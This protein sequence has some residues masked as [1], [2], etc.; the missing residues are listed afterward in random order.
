MLLLVEASSWQLMMQ[1]AF[2]QAGDNAT[3]HNLAIGLLLAWLP[4]LILSSIVD[5]NPVASDSSRLK[6]NRLIDAVRRALLNPGLRETYIRETGRAPEEFAWT[7]QLSNED[8]FHEHFFEKFAGQGCIRW[9]YGVAHP[10]L[11]SIEDGYVTECG[12]GWLHNADEARTAFVKGPFSVSGLQW[13]DFREAWQILS[14]ILVVGGSVGGAFT[15]SYW[16]PT[17]GLGCR[18]GGY[19]I[20]VVI[21][22]GLFLVEM[23]CWILISRGSLSVGDHITRFGTSIQRRLS[24]SP[25]NW[26]TVMARHWSYRL[27]S[28]WTSLS[29]RDKIEYLLIRPCEMFNSVWLC[30]IVFAQT[31]GSYQNCRCMAST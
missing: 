28:G 9:H 1:Q 22:L 19:L 10:I 15:L 12:R 5:R 4:V 11:A 26:W 20:Y 2:D 23:I 27:I 18:S 30:Y 3:A 31:F 29:T 17:V 7:L 16:T 8:Y 13:F 6:L 21:A 25:S 14:S 24:R